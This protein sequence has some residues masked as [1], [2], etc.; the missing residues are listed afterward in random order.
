VY[1]KYKAF[2]IGNFLLFRFAPLGEKPPHHVRLCE[3][4]GGRMRGA[5]TF[6]LLFLFTFYVNTHVDNLRIKC[7]NGT[8]IS[9]L[10]D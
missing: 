10:S 3:H 1:L 4:R 8:V 5:E 9:F 6:Q 2:T 7:E